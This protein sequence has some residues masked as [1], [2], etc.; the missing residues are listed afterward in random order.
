MDDYEEGKQDNSYFNFG[1]GVNIK[2]VYE[3][4]TLD[5]G[6]IPIMRTRAGSLY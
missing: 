5:N 3:T 4:L 6:N 1:F 2:Y